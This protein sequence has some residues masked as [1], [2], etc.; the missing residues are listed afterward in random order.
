MCVYS[1]GIS[2]L[3]CEGRSFVLAVRKVLKL[4]KDD[5]IS[6]KENIIPTTRVRVDN[7]TQNRTTWYFLINTFANRL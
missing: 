6:N 4:F 3:E 5:E 1:F 7:K 2:G